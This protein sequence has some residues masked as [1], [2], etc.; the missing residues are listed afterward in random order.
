MLSLP[1][2]ALAKAMNSGTVFTDKDGLI[3]DGRAGEEAAIWAISCK[4]LKLSLSYSVELEAFGVHQRGA[5]Y[6]HLPARVRRFRW[7]YW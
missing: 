4:K 2:L 1:G 3:E 7:Q 5:A 6:S